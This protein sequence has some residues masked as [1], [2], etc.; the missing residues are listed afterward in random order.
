MGSVYMILNNAQKLAIQQLPIDESYTIG[1]VADGEDK[2]Y[3]VHRVTPL[4]Y[5]VCVY[6]LMICL[7]LDYLQSPEEVI[8]F[9]ETN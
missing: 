7:K 4:E 3:E 1:G 5:K 2:Q 6:A 8:R 9:I